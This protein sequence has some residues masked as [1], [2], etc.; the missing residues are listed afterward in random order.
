MMKYW[1]KGFSGRWFSFKIPP[2]L[3]KELEIIEIV[4]TFPD[5]PDLI[6]TYVVSALLEIPPEEVDNEFTSDQIHKIFRLV[7][8]QFIS[9][10]DDFEPTN[11]NRQVSPREGA[12]RLLAYLAKNGVEPSIAH[13]LSRDDLMII[14]DEI[15]KL[16][17]QEVRFHAETSA[18]NALSLAF[19]GQSILDGQPTSADTI[20]LSDLDES[21]LKSMED[22]GI[23]VID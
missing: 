10:S 18:L 5:S 19:G 7:S 21:S 23:E 9:D 2:P 6:L 12:L 22:W 1:V 13:T 15:N 8:Q 3:F 4:E 11:G 16:R 20:V 14:A 17:E